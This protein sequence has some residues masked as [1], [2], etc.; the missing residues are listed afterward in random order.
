MSNLIG[1]KG[2][3]R[4]FFSGRRTNLPLECNAGGVCSLCCDESTVDWCLRMSNSRQQ[5]LSCMT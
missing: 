3:Q 2:P 4:S 1:Q 5:H